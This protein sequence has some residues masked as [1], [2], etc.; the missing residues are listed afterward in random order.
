M[1]SASI[2]GRPVIQGP[3]L[4]KQ[5]IVVLQ[6]FFI[7][8]F[9]LIELIF[10]HGTGSITGIFILL[11]TFGAVKFGRT[12]TRYVSV[13]TPPLALAGIVLLYG[14][15]SSGFSPARIGVDFISN[16]A[17]QAPFL[18]VMSLYGWF[19]YFNEKAKGR[20]SRKKR[21]G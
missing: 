8:F 3:G 18:L 7:S 21:D 12:G 9:A 15:L 1:S 4:K 16:I 17:S 14:L 20:P 5:G 10:R 11:V 2:N 13:V 19:M 6:T